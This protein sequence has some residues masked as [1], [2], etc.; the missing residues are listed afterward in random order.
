MPNQSPEQ[1][2]R[3]TISTLAG[4]LARI[5]RTCSATSRNKPSGKSSAEPR[6]DSSHAISPFRSTARPLRKKALEIA[7]LPTGSDPGESAR[8]LAQEQ[9]VA[10]I[11]RAC[12]IDEKLTPFDAT[13]RRNYRDWILKRNA[14]RL[15]DG[16]GG[17]GKMLQLFGAEMDGLIEEVNRELVA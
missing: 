1:K 11:R 15:S 8:T 6:W 16:Q 5:E 10:L 17:L 14:A 7:G 4:R 3:D 2:A 9:L 13:V 12:G